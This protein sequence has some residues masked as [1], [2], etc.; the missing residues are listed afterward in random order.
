MGVAAYSPEQTAWV[1]SAR[2]TRALEYKQ[3]AAEFASKWGGRRT[4]EQM[5]HLYRAA[6]S[7]ATGVAADASEK[8][9]TRAELRAEVRAA[10][11]ADAAWRRNHPYARFT[12]QTVGARRTTEKER[13]RWFVT[14]ASP[15]TAQSR[16]D[17][18][19]DGYEVSSNLHKGF[20]AAIQGWSKQ[21][22]GEVV[23]LP[24]HA[25]MPALKG[26]PSHFDPALEDARECFAGE[27]IFNEHLRALDV[28]L[29]PQQVSPL[30]GLH[31]LRGGRHEL[32]LNADGKQTVKR[33]NTSMLIAH[34]K[35]DMEVVPTGNGTTPRLLHATGACTMPEYLKNRIGRLAHEGHVIGGLVVEVDGDKFW[36][37][38]VQ[39]SDDGSFVDLGIRYRPDGGTEPVRAEA[40][41][42]GDVHAGRHSTEVLEAW[43][44][45]SDR[46]SPKK[47]F[48]EDVFDGGSISHHKFSKGL[49]TA[50]DKPVFES[51]ESELSVCARLMDEIYTHIV[52]A[53]GELLVVE[54]NH[55][56]H[57]HRYLNEGRYIKDKPNYALAHRMVVEVLDGRDPLRIRLDPGGRYAWLGSE[58]DY[59]VEG[60]QMAAHGHLGANG[61][62]GTPVQLERVH[63]VGMGGHTHTPG[64]RGGQYTCGH[65]S[66]ARHGYNPGPSSW[67]NT[68]GAVYPGGG[69]QLV[70]CIDG[71]F[72]LDDVLPEDEDGE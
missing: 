16:V 43:T 11:E 54:S 17:I 46:I 62:K 33:F 57:L 71:R 48:V 44:R 7:A 66:Q 3:I 31:R 70:T 2:N 63:A 41:R 32:V 59:F 10:R 67:L 36:V 51:L 24:L 35:Q 12:R 49:T 64:I 52:P 22:G 13:G 60:V 25:H 21:C 37:R 38:Q 1:L 68:A 58:D 8:P 26:Q 4:S 55:H 28:H 23:V 61:V 14:A 6:S 27:Y 40:F 34:A 15:V 39:A 69:R 47:V 20:W 45:L 56:E 30:T 18:D 19:D 42:P 5:R 72:C 50:L 53:D 29:N 65:S 9:K